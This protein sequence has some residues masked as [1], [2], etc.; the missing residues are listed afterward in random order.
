[1]T[2]CSTLT[3]R[4]K[5]L[6]KCEWADGRFCVEHAKQAHANF[7]QTNDEG[8]DKAGSRDDGEKDVWPAQYF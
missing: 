3:H 5:I 2:G 4:N 7:V 8:G 1:M 6:E